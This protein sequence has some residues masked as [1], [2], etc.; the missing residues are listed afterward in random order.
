MT[1][2]ELHSE[3]SALRIDDHDTVHHN[4]QTARW[5]CMALKRLKTSLLF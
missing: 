3:P 5:R 4:T 2:G 1:R